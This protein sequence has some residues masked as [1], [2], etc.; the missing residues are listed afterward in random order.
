[1]RSRLAWWLVSSA[2]VDP[3]S[4]MPEFKAGSVTV[5]ALDPEEMIR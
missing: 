3:V 5:R 2:A 4:S 1:M